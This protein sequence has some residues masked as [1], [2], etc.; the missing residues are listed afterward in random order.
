MVGPSPTSLQGRTDDIV[1]LLEAALGLRD[2][3]RQE[4]LAVIR[5]L[6]DEAQAIKVHVGGRQPR[7]VRF[8]FFLARLSV[9]LG[10][11]NTYGA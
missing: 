4:P 1:Q 5:P 6:G 3:D 11:C 9:L 10:P 2:L 8:L 7:N